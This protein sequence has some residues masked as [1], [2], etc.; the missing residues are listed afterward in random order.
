M[1]F[2]R[3]FANR[4]AVSLILMRRW[5]DRTIAVCCLENRKKDFFLN[6]IGTFQ[7]ADYSNEV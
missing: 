4:S 3:A 5:D 7:K 1:L 6:E 2:K